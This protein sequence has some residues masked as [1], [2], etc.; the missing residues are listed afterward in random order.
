MGERHDDVELKEQ[1]EDLNDSEFDAEEDLDERLHIDRP[2]P[3]GRKEFEEWS[4]RIIQD[5][6]LTVTPDSIKF[7]LAAMVLQ[8]GNTDAF[9]PNA[10]FI[11]AL[12]KAAANQVAQA[13]MEELNQKK[14]ARI[15]AEKKA[16]LEAEEAAKMEASP[17]A[18][19]EK[20]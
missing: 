11:S 3:V 18:M 19:D 4:D 15:E 14:K 16:Q 10:Y 8:L 20:E 7:T 9:K 12:R 5:C 17:P 13:V 1:I 2:L 6:G